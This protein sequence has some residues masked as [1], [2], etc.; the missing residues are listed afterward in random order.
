MS[1]TAQWNIGSSG[2][3]SCLFQPSCV[4][5]MYWSHCGPFFCIRSSPREKCPPQVPLNHPT[6]WIT[7]LEACSRTSTDLGSRRLLKESVEPARSPSLDRWTFRSTSFTG[8]V[9]D[10][11]FH[12]SPLP[13]HQV[14]TAM[15]RTWHPEHFVC[16]HCQEEIGSKNFFERDGQPYCEKDYHNLF[17][18]R[19]HYCNG[20]ILDV[21]IAH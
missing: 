3:C 11:A 9:L 12:L 14:V 8:T 7:C 20:P 16:T 19:C 21:S 6:S 13:P 18:P 2:V 4:W 10:T 5:L 17:S 15:G 1:W